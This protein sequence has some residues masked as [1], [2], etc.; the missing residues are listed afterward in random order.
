MIFKIFD[1]TIE[2]FFELHILII[3]NNIEEKNERLLSP[4]EIHISFNIPSLSD[5]GFIEISPV[6]YREIKKSDIYNTVSLDTT[7]DYENKYCQDVLTFQTEPIQF[8]KHFINN[9][10]KCR[11]DLNGDLEH[12]EQMDE[13]SIIFKD[14]KYL[15]TF[16]DHFKA[17]LRDSA[18]GEVTKEMFL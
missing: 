5:L 6:V 13:Y 9:G 10:Y 17:L 1:Q 3:K 8:R 7:Y 18:Q 12:Q 4:W 16:V 14:I 2:Q 15:D 11:L